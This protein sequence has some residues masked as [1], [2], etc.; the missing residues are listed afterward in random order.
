MWNLFPFPF[1]PAE[2]LGDSLPIKR[3]ADNCL[4]HF[5]VDK[6]FCVCGTIILEDLSTMWGDV[7]FQTMSCNQSGRVLLDYWPMG[8]IPYLYQ[9]RLYFGRMIWILT[10]PLPPSPISRLNQQYTGKQ[11]EKQFAESLYQYQFED[12][13]INV[14]ENVKKMFHNCTHET[15]Y[16]LCHG[17]IISAAIMV[18]PL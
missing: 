2:L 14:I 8:S 5:V 17:I 12:R 1:I 9:T 4:L 16:K 11:K 10:H 13:V 15:V 6:Y 18:A 7:I 3:C